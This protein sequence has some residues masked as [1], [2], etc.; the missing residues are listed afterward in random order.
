MQRAFV[1]GPG[2]R[3]IEQQVR[4]PPPSLT[5]V[6]PPKDTA[7]RDAAVAVLDQAMRASARSVAADEVLLRQIALVILSVRFDADE[8]AEALST[9]RES[10]KVARL[11]LAPVIAEKALLIEATPQCFTAILHRFLQL[12]QTEPR[13]WKRRDMILIA[14]EVF[15]VSVRDVLSARRTKNI[16][17]P[18]QTAAF[19]CK[20]FTP[21]SYP[22]IGLA[23]GGRDHTTAL[24][25]VRKIEALCEQHGIKCAEDDPAA[26]AKAV[27]EVASIKPP[28]GIEV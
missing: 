11:R 27:A 8:A 15:G 14:C 2:M 4:A 23:L 19:L 20:R 22:E 3:R 28:R 16:T 17:L 13:R 26:W 5:A 24:H 9:I 6:P 18:R 7:E 12:Q 1:I 21:S 10:V 25:S